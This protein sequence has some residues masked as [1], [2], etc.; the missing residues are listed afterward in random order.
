M[1][2]KIEW[3][4]EVLELEPGSRVFFP[5][6]KLLTE[7]GQSEEAITMLKQGLLRHPDHVEARLLLVELLFSR[8]ETR[9]VQTEIDSLAEI[10][11]SYPGFWSA[12]CE[13]L[14]TTP[15]LQDASLAL[16][17][18][19]AALQGK[20]VSWSAIIQQGLSTILNEEPSLAGA[21]EEQASSDTAP[22]AL[23]EQVAHI[24]ARSES[25]PAAEE[26]ATGDAHQEHEDVSGEPETG[27]TD[28]VAEAELADDSD[29]GLEASTDS[30][31][32]V[33]HQASALD[34][35]PAA[36][37]TDDTDAMEASH[38]LDADDAHE[39]DESANHVAATAEEPEA[40]EDVE[41]ASDMVMRTASDER[42]DA[43][44]A[45]D[46][47]EV[48]ED[49]AAEDTESY[50]YDSQPSMFAEEV[51]SRVSTLIPSEDE[52]ITM[53]DDEDDAEHDADD[54]VE[55]A[56]SLR[57]RTMAEVLAEQGD[58]TSALDIYHELMRNASPDERASLEARAEELAQRLGVPSS[59][60]EPAVSQ[61]EE[62]PQEAE[63]STR[64]VGLLESLAQRLEERAR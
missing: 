47:G 19:S 48:E 24:L 41:E 44:M 8:D 64:L 50:G 49:L 1:K 16:R 15:A 6:A 27:A 4:K 21:E 30:D 11:A 36:T 32:A 25:Q 2:Q 60:T 29:T 40:A 23:A 10:F 5:L 59:A 43:D 7:D 18:F 22:S 39:P 31:A 35:Q 12:W 46:D 58:V 53:R 61:E 37:E 52:A 42:D 45:D 13:R 38:H 55:E 62:Q 54:E 14:S 20:N 26:H 3:Y 9:E 28:T 34:A 57:T 33:E 56:F 63:D 17:F 51:R